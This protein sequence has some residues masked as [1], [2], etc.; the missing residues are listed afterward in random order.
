M[1]NAEFQHKKLEDT[2][3]VIRSH[4]SKNRQHNVLNKEGKR[5]QRG[6]NDLQSTAQKTKDRAIK[7]QK[8]KQRG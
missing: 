2:K 1:T 5:R 3:G 6:N 7:S 4:I 8:N